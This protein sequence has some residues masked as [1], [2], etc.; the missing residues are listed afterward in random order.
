MPLPADRAPI[1]ARLKL[2]A[3]LARCANA[4]EAAQREIARLKQ[5]ARNRAKRTKKTKKTKR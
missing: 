1:V 4:L 5:R 2:E 3:A